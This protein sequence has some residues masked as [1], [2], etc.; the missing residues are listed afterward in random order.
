MNLIRR[1]LVTTTTPG[2]GDG[3]QL[4]QKAMVASES[5]P[6]RLSHKEIIIS[7][8]HQAKTNLLVKSQERTLCKTHII[9]W[10]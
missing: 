6:E 7:T 10:I 4:A 2:L 8:V 1:Q 3:K 9:S 5:G